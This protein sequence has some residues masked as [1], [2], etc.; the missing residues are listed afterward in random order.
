MFIGDNRRAVEMTDRALEVAEH[1]GLVALLAD[2]LITKGS[3]LGDLGR[4]QEGT[5]VIETGERLA[6]SAGLAATLLRGINNRMVHQGEI[7]PAAVLEAS[8]EGL[9][10]SRRMGQRFWTFGFSVANGYACYRLGQWDRAMAVFA[11]ALAEDPASEDRVQLLSNAALVP[12]FRGDDVEDVLAEIAALVGASTDLT[13]VGNM[14]EARG[15]AALAAGRLAHATVE[16]R[17]AAELSASINGTDQRMY[18]AHASLWGGDI[19]EASVDLEAIVASGF[20]APT[21]EARRLTIGAGLAAADGRQAESL[22][23]YRDA[24]R[25]W[26]ELGLVFDEALT[27]IDMATLLDADDAEVRAAADSA[28]AILERLGA[29]PLLARLEAAMARPPSAATP[30]STRS[31]DLSNV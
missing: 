18:A 15:A 10:L 25:R 20:R 8:T 2:T 29:K 11:E 30:E 23:M 14:R 6:R 21:V 12:A 28:R 4:I 5:G 13:L 9:A 17:A 26:R 3:A 7:D 1:A 16:Y 27:F 19:A 22:A 24:L 31:R